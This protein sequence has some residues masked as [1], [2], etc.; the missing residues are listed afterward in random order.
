MKQRLRTQ[1]S[2]GFVLIALVIV[3]LISLSANVLINRQFEKYVGAQ[4]RAFSDSLASNLTYQYDPTSKRW[5]TDYIHGVGM[6]ALNDGYIIK[7]TDKNGVTLWDAENHDMAQCHQMMT[8]ISARMAQQRPHLRGDFVKHRYTLKDGS[9]VIGTVTISYYSPYYLNDNEFRFLD[10]LNLIL[11]IIGILSIIGA[12]IA[13]LIFAKRL[14]TPIVNTIDAAH[15]IAQGDYNIRVNENTQTAELAE[16]EASINHMATSLEQQS[17]LRKRLTTDVAHELRTPLANVSAHLEMMLDG[18]WEPTPERLQSSFD[19]VGRL[20]TLVDSLQNLSQAESEHLSLE[21]RKFDVFELAKS[22]MA[23]FDHEFAA[24]NI[25]PSVS[26][27]STLIRADY[28]RL[29]QVLINL[30]SNA[31]KYSPD[32]GSVSVEVGK[33]GASAVIKVADTGIGIE[34]HDLP[35]IFERFYRSDL[36]RSRATGGSGIGLTIVRSIVNAHG[37]QIEVESALGKG[38]TFTITLPQNQ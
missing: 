3:A 7:L 30:I 36:S 5:N 27:Q 15:A 1:L 2:V 21:Y 31:L 23:E 18:V 9:T 34:Q 26:G 28:N 11:L 12:T 25:K 24:R 37:G 22:T 13:A 8:D 10:S 17:A 6:Y 29:Q 38:T 4:Q 32:G 14:A 16:L 35:L 20:T 33:V 19:E